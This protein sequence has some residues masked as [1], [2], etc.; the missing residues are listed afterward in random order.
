MDDTHPA[1]FQSGEQPKKQGGFSRAE[2]TGEHIQPGL[3]THRRGQHRGFFLLQSGQ[4][5]DQ[6][7][8]RRLVQ[9]VTDPPAIPAA[10]HQ[11]RIAQDLH[12]VGKSGLAHIKMLQ[13]L[14]G[15]H[16]VAAEHG[17]NLAP[18]LI[19]YGPENIFQLGEGSFHGF[20]LALKIVY[21]MI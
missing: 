13:D 15:T 16:L 9:L 1:H 12:M 3:F 7:L 19:G 18:N 6:L 17:E 4:S 2:K 14:A 5:V 21:L 11:L 10:G 8:D 20:H